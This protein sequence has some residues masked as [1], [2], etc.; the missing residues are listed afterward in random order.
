[1]TLVPLDLRDVTDDK[2]QAFC[3]TV[4]EKALVEPAF[5]RAI[6]LELYLTCNDPK[7]TPAVLET[8][9]EWTLAGP[10]LRKLAVRCWLDCWC[11]GRDELRTM[12]AEFQEELATAEH[13]RGSKPGWFISIGSDVSSFF[14]RK[15]L[16]GMVLDAD[17]RICE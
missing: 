11:K 5:Q 4:I 13:K 14:D 7:V 2:K 1:M 6:P 15:E 17:A 8:I 16:I 9:Y 3:K 12:P 10:L